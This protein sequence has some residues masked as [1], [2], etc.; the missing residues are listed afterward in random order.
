METLKFKTNINCGGCIATVS[1]ALNELKDIQ[2]WEVDTAN[3]DKI[4]TVNADDGLTAGQV[5]DALKQKGY[6]AEKV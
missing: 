2:H 5:I 4:L 1:P 3:P 6:K